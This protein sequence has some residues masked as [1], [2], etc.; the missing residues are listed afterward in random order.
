MEHKKNRLSLTYEDY[1][2]EG[3]VSLSKSVFMENLTNSGVLRTGLDNT[4]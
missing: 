2:T 4:L 1:S 3:K